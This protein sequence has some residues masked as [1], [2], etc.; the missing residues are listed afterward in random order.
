[1]LTIRGHEADIEKVLTDI[2]VLW[3]EEWN[4]EEEENAAMQGMCD[5]R[6]EYN[7]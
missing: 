7:E 6:D 3:K 2:A 5:T 1:M 4:K